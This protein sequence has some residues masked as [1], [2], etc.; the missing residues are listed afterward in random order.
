MTTNS[1]RR[2]IKGTPHA[3]DTE[4][5]Y[6]AVNE[7]SA[8]LDAIGSGT[9]TGD[10]TD[11]NPFSQLAPCNPDFVIDRIVDPAGEDPICCVNYPQGTP[12]TV[13]K[14]V[15]RQYKK[16][17]VTLQS[18]EKKIHNTFED[19]TDQNNQD[20][21]LNYR[22]GKYLPFNKRFALWQLIMTDENGHHIKARDENSN[23][24]LA[25]FDTGPATLGPPNG[26]NLLRNGRLERSKRY[27]VTA[28]VAT[29]NGW[30]AP[31]EGQEAWAWFINCDRERPLTTT[32]F[33][34]T[35]SRPNSVNPIWDK[36]NGILKWSS[37]VSGP[38]QRLPHRVLRASDIVYLSGWLSKSFA[39]GPALGADLIVS[40]MSVDDQRPGSA[41]LILTTLA[42]VT[43]RIGAPASLAPGPPPVSLGSISTPFQVSIQ[44]PASYNLASTPPP[45]N[46]S[47]GQWVWLQLANITGVGQ[48]QMDRLRL[49]YGDADWSPHSEE[50]GDTV[51]DVE[52]TGGGGR[53]GGSDFS[54][55]SNSIE[56]GQG[57]ILR[58][59]T[60]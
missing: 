49:G 23:V 1:F 31:V 17:G 50:N 29:A 18:I 4:S 27:S 52:I 58:P 14:T 7:L 48:F 15:L 3:A 53:G 59:R 5:L 6:R 38:S 16:D 21:I 51:N 24:P 44:M 41:G 26:H 39:I 2:P 34:S 37:T 60:D 20:G 30:T 8:E 19:I 42:T 55:T 22:F 10:S 35:P 11:E 25:I 40:I 54:G 9:G 28:A 13:L 56:P 32:A 46:D 43:T 47:S 36:A 45:D 12:A 57:L 33:V